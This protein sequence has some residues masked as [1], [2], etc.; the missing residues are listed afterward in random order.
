MN[1]NTGARPGGP[2]RP[3]APEHVFSRRAR[4]SRGAASSSPW[5]PDRTQ[6]D[7]GLKGLG[8]KLFAGFALHGLLVWR[9]PT[10]VHSASSR[11]AGC[12]SGAMRQRTQGPSGAAV[13]GVGTAAPLR[14]ES[15]APRH[16]PILSLYIHPTPFQLSPSGFI[17]SSKVPAK[18][19]PRSLQAP[20]ARTP[21]LRG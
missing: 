21:G 20:A 1:C 14:R 9:A 17:G 7:R 12:G 15:D 18:L 5:R 10:P 16:A 19:Y 13:L 8:H 2:R 11:G 3:L 6:P 4:P